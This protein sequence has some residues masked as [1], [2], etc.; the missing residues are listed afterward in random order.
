MGKYD[1]S[2]T[3]VVPIFDA[4]MDRDPTGCS[5]LPV[6]LKIGSFS[7]RG[8][9]G[10][11]INSLIDGHGRWWGR[12]E[13]QLD[14]PKALLRWLIMNVKKPMS[15]A[16]WG[17]DET[18]NKRELLV[19]GHPET[20]A[21]A[22]LLLESRPAQ[23]AWYVLE[24]QSR[25]DAYLETERLIL[26]I[27]G[28][29]TERESTT[30][31]NWMRRRSQI[32]RHMDASWEIRGNKKVFGTMLVEGPGGAEAVTPSEHWQ[33]EAESQIKPDMIDASL[34]HRTPVERKQIAEGFLGV[35]TWQRLCSELDLPWPSIAN[36]RQTVI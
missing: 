7:S 20:R 23:R 34:P 36:I 29:R 24:G 27:E 32:L 16:C 11:T 26:V 6:I 35:A 18:R 19:A 15:E 2:L 8:F 10:L 12:Q 3:R 1:S 31:T 22:L 13:R 14:P 4:L 5:W 17:S 30:T 28:K 25:P 21:E 9:N 33:K